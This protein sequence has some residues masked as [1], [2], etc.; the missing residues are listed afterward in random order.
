MHQASS[1]TNREYFDVN[2]ELKSYARRKDPGDGVTNHS[3][4][5]LKNLARQET[6]LA[7]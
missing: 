5:P 4:L 2:F 6:N 3:G 1:G 7:R